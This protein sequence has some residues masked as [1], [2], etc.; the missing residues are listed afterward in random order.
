MKNCLLLLVISLFAKLSFA[1]NC[2]ASFLMSYDSTTSIFSTSPINNSNSAQHNWTIFVNELPLT[3]STLSSNLP[4]GGM[5]VKCPSGQFSI[6][7]CH[8]LVDTVLNCNVAGSDSISIESHKRCNPY[9]FSVTDPFS[10]YY[11]H[12]GSNT[13][14]Q[15]I[16]ILNG[17]TIAIGDTNWVSY[18]FVDT[19][20]YSVTHT[21]YDSLDCTSSSD[22]DF[23]TSISELHPTEI[24]IFPNPFTEEIFVKTGFNINATLYNLEGKV[25]VNG[26][27]TICGLGN[28]TPGFYVAVIRNKQGEIIKREKLVKLE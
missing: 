8:Y 3:L 25:I 4:D 17:D 21:I 26:S 10:A 16:W 24:K 28:I 1:Q 13:N 7:V 12:I 14:E 2:D 5:E 20:T 19:V 6:R 11:F 18:N 15:D 22:V 23:V 27:N 9:F